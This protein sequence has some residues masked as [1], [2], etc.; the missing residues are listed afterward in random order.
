[1]FDF[2]ITFDKHVIEDL[3]NDITAALRP[4]ADKYGI[5]MIVDRISYDNNEATVRI[6]AQN[7]SENSRR[8]IWNHW[9]ETQHP[10]DGLLRREDFGVDFT[11]GDHLYTIAGVNLSSQ[12]NCVIVRHSNGMMFATDIDTIINRLG[13][14]DTAGTPDLE[15][16]AFLVGIRSIQYGDRF[17]VSGQTYEVIDIDS[18]ATAY[19]IIA[20]NIKTNKTYKF[21]NL[22]KV[23]TKE[24]RFDT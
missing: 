8:K 15:S 1:M 22:F 16:N 14:K 24:K 19:P 9:I 13:R 4:I 3:G 2:N 5:N 17:T 11:D 12:K 23:K 20:R 10:A 6:S 18:R 21:P 7:Y